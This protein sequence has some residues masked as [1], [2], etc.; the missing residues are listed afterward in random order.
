M[1]VDDSERSE[2]T[3]SQQLLSPRSLL[4]R[5]DQ[6]RRLDIVKERRRSGGNS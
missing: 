6:V 5:Q 4:A 1:V 3:E 2:E